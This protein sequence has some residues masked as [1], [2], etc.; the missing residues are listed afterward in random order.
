[1]ELTGKAVP[2]LEGCDFLCLLVENPQFA[3]ST[4]RL[5]GT[6]TQR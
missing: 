1:M 2:L 5:L 4:S 6:L 3:L